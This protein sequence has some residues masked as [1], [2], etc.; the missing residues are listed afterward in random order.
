MRMVVRGNTKDSKKDVA[1]KK[2]L[3]KKGNAKVDKTVTTEQTNINNKKRDYNFLA[4]IGMQATPMSPNKKTGLIFTSELKVML[5][6]HIDKWIMVFK[7]VGKSWCDKLF[8]D[9]VRNV[10]DEGNEN[11]C[12]CMAFKVYDYYENNI[13][14]MAVQN[15][16]IAE[17]IYFSAL[18]LGK[19]KNNQIVFIMK[20]LCEGFNDPSKKGHDYHHILSFNENNLFFNEQ[21]N[22][23]KWSDIIGDVAALHLLSEERGNGVP[24]GLYN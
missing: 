14:K 1:G 17:R 6:Q 11:Y 22:K 13:R 8:W 12:S 23:L 7:V 9:D 21:K 18:S 4:Q 10:H 24:S 20:N 2:T 3:Q 16:D 5:L 19:P 15:R